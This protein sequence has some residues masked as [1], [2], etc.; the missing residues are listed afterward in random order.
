MLFRSGVVVSKLMLPE[1]EAVPDESLG[2]LRDM[3]RTAANV[4]DAAAEGAIDG[5]KLALNV[6]GMLVA[7]V[8]LIALL[9][10]PLSAIDPG[11]SFQS[12][13]GWVL[14]P[15]AWTMGAG[16]ESKAIGSLMGTQVIATELVAY[17]DLAGLLKSHA[18][19]PR[20]ATIATYA[21]CGFANQIGRAHV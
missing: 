18:I 12:I 9:N 8:S 17:K 16:A 20:G 15:L 11:L 3:P 4:M 21:L 6:A 13:L 10:W 19:T 1:T 2:A 7:F 5:L 14:Q